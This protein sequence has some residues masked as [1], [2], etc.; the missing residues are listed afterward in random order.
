VILDAFGLRERRYVHLIGGGGKTSLMFALARAL[1]AEGCTVLTTTTTRIGV[2]GPAES[3]TVVIGAD[4]RALVGPLRAACVGQRHVTAA[5][6]HVVAERKLLGLPVAELDALVAAGVAEHLIVEADGSAGRPLK[7]HAGQEPVVSLLADLV[8]AVVGATCLGMP[9]DDAH[10]HR[11]ALLRERL[12]R[13]LGA[14]IGAEDVAA[15]LFHPEGY[16]ARVGR[17]T[18]VAL[19]VNQADS[20]ETLAAA[21][22]ITEAVTGAD[23]GHRLG[24]VVVGDVRAGDFSW[25]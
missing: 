19:F 1:V 3:A 4:A 24:R 22:A 5:R 12:G 18:A 11:A 10:V 8:V 14:R 2:P 9:M 23:R 17:D 6:A 20:A 21:R 16:L 25:R 7:A 13:P 15:I